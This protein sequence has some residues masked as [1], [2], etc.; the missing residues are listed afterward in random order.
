MKVY[1]IIFAV[2]IF[3]SSIGVA[4]NLN[5]IAYIDAL[6]RGIERPKLW[7]FIAIGGNNGSGGLL[8]YLLK[9]RKYP[10]NIKEEDKNKIGKYKTRLY[11]FLVM[12][13]I[14]FIGMLGFILIE[15]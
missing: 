14:S 8:L 6:S 7:S 12:I 4:Y 13:F 11:L 1:I 10:S 3:T 9:R 5:R 2:V 15:N